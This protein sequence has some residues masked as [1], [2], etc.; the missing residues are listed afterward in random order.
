MRNII[1]VVW[2]K[3]LNAHVEQCSA[4]LVNMRVYSDSFVISIKIYYCNYLILFSSEKITGSKTVTFRSFIDT[5]S[6]K[7]IH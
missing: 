3:I 6:T 4:V 1:N 5:Q 2:S 7:H